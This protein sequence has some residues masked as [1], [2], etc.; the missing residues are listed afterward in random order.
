MASGCQ[1]IVEQG[2]IV[3]RERIQ[4]I[5]A[6][7]K[8][9][10]AFDELETSLKSLSLKELG[11]DLLHC[12]VIP[13][14]FSHDS[15]EEKLWAKY[16][17]ILCA[18]AFNYIN[19]P[20]TVIRTRGDSADILGITAEYSIVSDAKAF[21]LSRT[22]K[23]QK[24][25]KISALDD[26]RKSNT[27]ACLIAPL[28]QYPY[29]K[30]QIYSQAVAKNV[31]LLSFVHLRFLLEFPP[32]KS[33]RSLWEI[34][35]LLQLS[36]SAISYWQVVDAEIARLTHQPMDSLHNYKRMEIEDTIL[37]GQEAV[38][39]WQTVASSY[40]SLSREE[41]ILQLIRAEKIDQKIA[42]IEMT[43]N[44]AKNLYQ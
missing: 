39:Y 31:T 26:W 20:S 34:S 35:R 10:Y 43:I 2:Y 6:I 30:S 37:I 11:D 33:L 23:N 21:R 22:A 5:R 29:R 41:A 8:K 27:F 12:G 7:A 4:L 44:Y 38:E 40:Q 17:D 14:E 3:R 9:P 1:R 18:S 24:D 13:E 16:C 15:S 19:I 36:Q 32:R 42:V 25:F 28:Y